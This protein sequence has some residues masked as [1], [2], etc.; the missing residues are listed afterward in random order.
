MR[1]FRISWVFAC[2]LRLA[3]KGTTSES[4]YDDESEVSLTGSSP[5]RGSRLRT[6]Q[7]PERYA[8]PK[9]ERRPYPVL[10]LPEVIAGGHLIT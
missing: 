1:P 10:D 6:A 7:T 4:A 9:P 2:A 5:W 3:G 8:S